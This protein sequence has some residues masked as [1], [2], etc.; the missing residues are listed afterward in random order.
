MKYVLMVF[1][2]VV[3][4]VAIAGCSS[5]M[6]YAKQD[7]IGAHVGVDPATQTP[8]ITIGT[9]GS[10]VAKVP[11]IHDD[12]G[13]LI[14]SHRIQYYENGNPQVDLTDAQSTCGSFEGDANAEGSGTQLAIE[15]MFSTGGAAQSLCDGLGG[16][17]LQDSR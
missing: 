10:N 11:V 5:Q 8:R 7:V 17:L 3:A 2:L 12:T 14:T 6:L 16:M 15:S 9:M 4:A 13:E 1:A